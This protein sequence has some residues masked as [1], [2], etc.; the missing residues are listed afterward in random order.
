MTQ[1]RRLLAVVLSAVAALSAGCA[2]TMSGLGGEGS[3]ACKAPVGTQCT[4]V[5]GV[6]ANSTHGAVPASVLPKPAKAPASAPSAASGA[7]SSATAAVLNTPA[8][9]IRSQ[10]RVLRLWIAPWEDADGD[11]HEASVVHVLVDT[12]RW[13]IERV[14]PANRNRLDAVRPPIPSS[15]PVSGPPP[16]VESAS[17]AESGPDR[18]PPRMGPSPAD[19][20][21]QEP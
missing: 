10:P 15:A 11:L 13:L 9:P 16:A 17:R 1:L 2:S 3:Y 5:S 21:T 7:S 20:T 6:Y 19:G 8:T 18:F 4:S 14:V 12:G